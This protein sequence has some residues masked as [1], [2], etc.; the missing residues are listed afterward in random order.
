[1][2][3][4]QL[5]SSLMKADCYIIQWNLSNPTYQGTREMFQNVQDVGIL[6]FYVSQQKYLGTIIFCRMSQDV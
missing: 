2:K 4:Y 3:V 5:I 1:M 6:G